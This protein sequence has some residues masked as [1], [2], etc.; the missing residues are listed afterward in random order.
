MSSAMISR[1]ICELASESPRKKQKTSA[2]SH[3]LA[4]SEALSSASASLQQ[5]SS[6]QPQSTKAETIYIDISPPSS[7]TSSSQ[8][9]ESEAEWTDDPYSPPYPGVWDHFS[10]INWNPPPR[11]PEEEARLELEPLSPR[12]LHHDASPDPGSIDLDEVT[13]SARISPLSKMLYEHRAAQEQI[14]AMAEGGCKIQAAARYQLKTCTCYTTRANL[15]DSVNCALWLSNV[16]VGTKAFQIFDLIDCGSVHCVHMVPVTG[17]DMHV[18]VVFLHPEGAAAF[19]A[20]ST[21]TR[22]GLNLDR[23]RIEVEYDKN[24]GVESVVFPEYRIFSI[25]VYKFYLKNHQY[26]KNYFGQFC[27][28]ELDRIV[29]RRGVTSKIMEFRFQS[30]GKAEL[31]FQA[32]GKHPS[33]SG[34]CPPRYRRDPC[35]GSSRLEGRSMDKYVG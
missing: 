18:R 24:H 30:V 34:I 32:I 35:R 4:V 33:L 26:W 21:S 10:A 29:D 16:P 15:D 11:K 9:S 1:L 25:Q 27:N 22:A 14:A 13:S 6:S 5:Q 19:M 3:C 31:C 2:D 8:H 12:Q 17:A 28:L 20:K 7:P 23:R